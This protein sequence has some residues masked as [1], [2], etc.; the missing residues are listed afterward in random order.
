[1]AFPPAALEDAFTRADGNIDA[2][3]TS[4][5]GWTWASPM[6]TGNSNRRIVS[7]TCA[8]NA[9]AAQ[10]DNCCINHDF[11]SDIRVS[12][13]ITTIATSNGDYFRL[14]FR[15]P[16]TSFPTAYGASS[17]YYSLQFNRTATNDV[18]TIVRTIAGGDV[19][20]TPVSGS[21]DIG[22]EW[23]VG[24][25]VAV[26]CYEEGGATVIKVYRKPSGGS[27]TTLATYSD[28]QAGRPSGSKVGLEGLGP[29]AG[30]P[31]VWIVDDLG[32]ELY[33][34]PGPSTATLRVIRSGWRW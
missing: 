13:T 9:A 3:L 23:G 11:G 27:W 14:D 5:G 33:S 1:M 32:V 20:L 29:T 24:D 7:N 12:L 26:E 30:T 15:I 10:Y 21:E 22:G 25:E 19:D 2:D 6:H 8:P 17:T 4:V 18:F 28:S 31:S 16:Y 34:V